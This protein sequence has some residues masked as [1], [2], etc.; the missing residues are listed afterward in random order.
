M[1]GNALTRILQGAVVG[2]AAMYMLD[3]DRGRRRRAITRDKVQR[4]ANDTVHLA[5]QAARDARQRLH[6]VNARMQHRL[7]SSNATTVDELRLIERVRAAMGRCVSHPH[8][9]Q[10]G[11]HDSTIVLS[12]P[13]L[14]GEVPELLATV[15]AVPDVA[16]V[17]NHL[18][19]HQTDDGI[20]SLQGDGRQ[21]DSATQYW[22]PTVRLAALIGGGVLALYGLAKRNASGLVLASAGVGVAARVVS[23]EP[24][25][26]WLVDTTR[27]LMRQL[28][29]P[30]DEEG[31]APGI[32]A[33]GTPMRDVMPSAA[34]DEEH[35][36]QA[37]QQ[38]SGAEAPLLG[39]DGTPS[40]PA[41]QRLVMPTENESNP[42]VPGPQDASRSVH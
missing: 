40:T 3:P 18:D 16:G 14:A 11:A 23:N 22:T 9:I 26:R 25:E 28:G 19:V 32:G 38:G 30:V 8:A 42:S 10:V 29:A 13:I 31:V 5:N 24:L 17:E 37:G 2:A 6:G 33:D 36:V 35:G 12:G 27:G 21:R 20:P 7:Q 4:F 39:D 1:S 15:R 34:H 41:A